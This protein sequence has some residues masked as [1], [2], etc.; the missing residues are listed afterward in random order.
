[1]K[2]KKSILV[3]LIIVFSIATYFYYKNY[4]NSENPNRITSDQTKFQNQNKIVVDQSKLD[5]ISKETGISGLKLSDNKIYKDNIEIGFRDEGTLW[6]QMW[7]MSGYIVTKDYLPLASPDP[8]YK[9]NQFSKDNI[10]WL[11]ME[12]S[13]RDIQHK[14]K[15]L[16]ILRDW[17]SNNFSDAVNE[18]NYLW[19][20]IK[21]DYG[22]AQKL[23]AESI[24]LYEEKGKIETQN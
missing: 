10:N 18:H 22:T 21:D 14:D 3:I 24:K 23:N 7:I 1:M 12:I 16:K 9:P 5:E 2:Y 17:N 6:Y 20:Y 19:N 13:V 11:I 15:L 4:A 8:S